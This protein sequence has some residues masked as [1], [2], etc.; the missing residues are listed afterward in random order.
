MTLQEIGVFFTLGSITL[1]IVFIGVGFYIRDL[2]LSLARSAAM[3]V[4]ESKRRREVTEERDALKARYD[5]LWA[6]VGSAI[7][8]LQRAERQL[9]ELAEPEPIPLD[10]LVEQY[11]AI[12]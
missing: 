8:S 3:H 11:G 1:G 12:E 6:T 7:D 4:W 2:R 10:V 5:A 9:A